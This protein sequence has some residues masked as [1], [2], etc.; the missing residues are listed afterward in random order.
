MTSI[1]TSQFEDLVTLLQKSVIW[2]FQEISRNI[3]V[4]MGMNKALGHLQLP[5][6]KMVHGANQ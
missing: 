1:M 3:H 5:V 2:V 6:R 4:M